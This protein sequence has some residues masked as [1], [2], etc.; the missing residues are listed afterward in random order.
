MINRE[1]RYDSYLIRVRYTKYIDIPESIEI[2]AECIEL[3]PSIKFIRS[4]FANM[5]QMIPETFTNSIS[6]EDVDIYI[7]NVK[8]GKEVMAFLQNQYKELIK[9]EA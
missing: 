6:F 7:E 9:E 5:C 8:K 4:E 2:D 1:Y 3:G